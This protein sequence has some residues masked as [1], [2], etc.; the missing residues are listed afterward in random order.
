[1]KFGMDSYGKREIADPSASSTKMP[2]FLFV[3]KKYH[4]LWGKI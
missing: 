4:N 2:E 1:M 3:Y